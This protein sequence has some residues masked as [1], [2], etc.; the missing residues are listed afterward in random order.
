MTVWVVAAIVLGG[1]VSLLAQSR[2][3]Q[4]MAAE[5]RMLQEQQQQL[6]L[7][8]AQVAEA[9]RALH[10]RFDEQSEAMRKGQANLE[11]TVKSMGNDLSVIRAQS[12]DTST[13]LGSLKDEIEALRRTVESL[14]SLIAQLIPPPPV[15]PVDPNAPVLPGAPSSG[16]V[17]SG[18]VSPGTVSPGTVS[19]GGVSQGG[20][21]PAQIVP[22]APPQLPPSALG[23]SPTRLLATAK[24]DYFNGQYGLAVSGFEAVIK[25]F[26]G[27][28]AAAEAQ[29][30]IGESYYLENKWVEA[31]AA[32]TLEI[33]NYPKSVFA[34]EAAYKRGLSLE[35]S[36]QLDAARAS[37][38]FAVKTY[39][40]TDGAR[41]A[42]QRLDGLNRQTPPRSQ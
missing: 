40:D 21:A 8:V 22:I 33:Q 39:P 12:Q 35:R 2:Q 30:F 26:A 16:T 27:T 38:E 28:Q 31:I 19:P 25:N 6:A 5:L 42:R 14:P 41:L 23:L 7:A 4:Q 32:Y 36:G 1:S 11:Q 10:P 20:G 34:P 3:E 13:R 17:S 18:T 15:A 24:G 37:L 29:F 9:I